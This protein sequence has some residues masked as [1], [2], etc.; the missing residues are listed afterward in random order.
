MARV[1]GIMHKLKDSFPQRILRLIYNSLIHP[2]FIYGFYLWGFNPKRLPILQK[3]RAVRILAIRPYLS[4][5]TPLFKSLKNYQVRRLI[6]YSVIQI[7]L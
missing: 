3:K 5:S 1:M 7:A 2:Y 6:H 4:H